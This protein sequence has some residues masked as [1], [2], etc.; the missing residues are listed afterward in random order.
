MAAKG[1]FVGQS[2][3]DITAVRDAM[4]SGILASMARGTSYTIAGRSFTFPG[5]MEAGAM[6]QEANYALGL[7]NGT[8]AKVVRA[9]F[10]TG[11]GRGSLG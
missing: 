9:N 11:M 1:I 5:L 3:E 10:N 6:I 8:R 4:Q 7:I 2:A